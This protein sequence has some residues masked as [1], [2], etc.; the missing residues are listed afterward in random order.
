VHDDQPAEDVREFMNAFSEIY[1]A[2]HRRSAKRSGLTKASRAVLTHLSRTG[3]LTVSEA[4]RHLDRAQSVVSE[5]VTRLV[6][7][8]LLERVAD[9]RDR[10]RTL[11]WLT[12]QGH[13]QLETDQHPL[14]T[15]RLRVALARLSADDR[16]AIVTGL[17]QLTS[18]DPVTGP[19]THSTERRSDERPLM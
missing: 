4:A 1:L 16:H 17:R 3:P 12:D 18:S 10:R 2:F 5:I 14:D 13:R 7:R 9:P 11:V 6:N 15:E 19:V 8:G